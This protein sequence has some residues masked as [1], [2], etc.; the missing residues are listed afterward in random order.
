MDILVEITPLTLIV[1]ITTMTNANDYYFISAIINLIADAPITNSDTPQVVFAFDLET[2][3]GA[4]L[5][6]QCNNSC[7]KAVF[8]LPVYLL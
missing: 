8:N 3:S 1:K 4:R 7:Y 6:S 5:F 2:T